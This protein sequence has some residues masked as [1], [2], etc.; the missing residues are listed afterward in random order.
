M[1]RHIYMCIYIYITT[2]FEEIVVTVVGAGR[3][4]LVAC[5]LNASCTTGVRIR[6]YAVEKN[7]NAVVTLRN[8]V[9]TGRVRWYYHLLIMKLVLISK[10]KQTDVE[11]GIIL[12]ITII[13]ILCNTL[14]EMWS[15]V[16]V[17]AGDM[18]NIRPIEEADILVSELLGIYI[19]KYMNIY[20]YIYIYINIYIY[21]H[22]Y[23]YICKYLCICIFTYIYIHR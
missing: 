15:N 16:T 6:V 1:Y 12:M 9:L 5:A 19:Y 8:R 17:I 14:T 3:G 13:L 22:V 20:M 23:I 7:M 4:P 11:F 21:I 10:F 2:E 18:R